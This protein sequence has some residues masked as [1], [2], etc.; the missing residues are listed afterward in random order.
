MLVKDKHKR[1]P[2]P[3]GEDNMLS[4][5]DDLSALKSIQSTCVGPERSTGALKSQSICA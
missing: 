5:K 3:T 1:T 4:N 2:R